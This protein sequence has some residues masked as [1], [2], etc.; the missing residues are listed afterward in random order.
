MSS[1]RVTITVPADLVEA[2]DRR[3]RML[4]RSRSWVLSEALRTYLG[5]GAVDTTVHEPAAFYA[6]GLGPSRR[7]QL[8]ADLALTPEERVEAAEGM[9]LV[10]TLRRRTGARQQVL[11]FDRLEDFM[12]W[13]RR[14]AL[15][16]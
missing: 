5:A 16:P 13:E 1:A 9:A 3:A 12:A 15:D 10:S 2:A 8:Q 4:G 6:A 11:T 14:E 7:A